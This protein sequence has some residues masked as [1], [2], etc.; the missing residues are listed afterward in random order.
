MRRD[1]T[2]APRSSR[3]SIGAPHSLRCPK[4]YAAIPAGLP[5]LVSIGAIN[6]T[7]QP[8]HLDT[9]E[10]DDR[11]LVSR[12]VSSCGKWYDVSCQKRVAQSSV[13]VD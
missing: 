5:Q 7:I 12:A 3:R 1:A 8:T 11:D 10:L 6:V 4:C 13:G 9:S 2:G